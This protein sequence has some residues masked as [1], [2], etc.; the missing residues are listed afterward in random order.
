MTNKQPASA[1][2]NKNKMGRR[3][4]VTGERE[5]AFNALAHVMK[6]HCKQCQGPI[7]YEGKESYTLTGYCPGCAQMIISND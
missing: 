4:D 7:T 5:E 6:Y 2:Y 3:S 1:S